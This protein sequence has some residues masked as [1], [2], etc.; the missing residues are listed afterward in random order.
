MATRREA[1]AYSPQ[2]TRNVR[3]LPVRRH[4]GG[5]NRM[6]GETVR[7]GG[8]TRAN[9]PRRGSGAPAV[10]VSPRLRAGRQ[11]REAV[12]GG[13]YARVRSPSAD[14][15]VAGAK[16]RLVASRARGTPVPL[17]NGARLL[18]SPAGEEGSDFPS[19]AFSHR[20]NP[21]ATRGDRPR[22]RC[23]REEPGRAQGELL[24]G[25][26]VRGPPAEVPPRTAPSP[27]GALC[28]KEVGSNPSRWTG[29]PAFGGSHPRTELRG[30]KSCAQCRDARLQPAA[31]GARNATACPL[32][33]SMT[34]SR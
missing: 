1:P 10:A 28:P 5:R 15:L 4:M 17:G 32:S 25:R 11:R 3:G 14:G 7:A 20:A 13:S 19:V 16:G 31:S 18:G 33:S 23:C 24:A 6:G 29:A 30:R 9:D 26:G 2:G 27:S 34:R 12:S 22:S 8:P 21:P